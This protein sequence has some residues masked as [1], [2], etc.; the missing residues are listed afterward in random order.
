MSP[1]L[2]TRFDTIDCGCSVGKPHGT[3][4][5][6]NYHGCGCEPCRVA[7]IR[8]VVMRRWQPRTVPADRSRELLQAQLSRGTRLDELAD[9][10]GLHVNTLRLIL[11]GVTQRVRRGTEDALMSQPLPRKKTLS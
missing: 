8:G 3:E 11:R 9:E 7:A 4:H 10:L 6:Y 1:A 5:V 2:R